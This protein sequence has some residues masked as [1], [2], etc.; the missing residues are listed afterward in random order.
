MINEPPLFLERGI[1][2]H[3]F[4]GMDSALRPSMKVAA[5]ISTSL[6]AARWRGQM[7]GG[8]CKEDRQGGRLPIVGGF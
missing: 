5:L 2:G 6:K 3:G 4:D 7:I 1:F 8:A